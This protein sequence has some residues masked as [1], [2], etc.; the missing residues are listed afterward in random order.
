MNGCVLS[1]QVDPQQLLACSKAGYAGNKNLF[2]AIAAKGG[3]DGGDYLGFPDPN[4]K[5][6][7]PGMTG[8]GDTAAQ[9]SNASLFSNVFEYVVG[10]LAAAIAVGILLK[11]KS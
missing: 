8:F 5:T 6:Y 3:A 4:P 1:S 11:R 2:P 7:T 10:G 9:T